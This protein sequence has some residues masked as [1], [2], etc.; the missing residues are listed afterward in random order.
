[1]HTGDLL[2]HR[3]HAS[4]DTT[5]GGTIHGWLDALREVRRSCDGET[6]VI[7][8]HGPTGAR[9]ALDE[10]A[11]YFERVRELVARERA[12]GRSREEIVKLPNTVFPNYG[13]VGEWPENL[14]IAFD[15]SGVNSVQ[16]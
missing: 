15:Q 13:F 7:A 10:Q 11:V 5:A 6:V 14:G 8:G 9:A 2:F 4:I 1:L 16:R 12:A 3:H